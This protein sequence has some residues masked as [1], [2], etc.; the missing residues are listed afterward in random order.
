MW[1][2]AK[3]TSRHESRAGLALDM[4]TNPGVVEAALLNDKLLDFVG[5]VDCVGVAATAAIVGEGRVHDGDPR[6]DVLG[7]EDAVLVPG[8]NTS[9]DRQTA[10]LV[11]DAARVAPQSVGA[12]YFEVAQAGV[13]IGRYY[14]TS[15]GQCMWRLQDRGARQAAYAQ[16]LFYCDDFVWI[17]CW[18]YKDLVMGR[19]PCD[20]LP[21]GSEGFAGP[22]DKLA[23]G[24]S[25]GSAD[26]IS[27]I[28]AV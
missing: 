4:V 1:P 3:V 12:A 16:R 24:T 25:V 19:S 15:L 20:R 28:M 27:N 13:C 9:R 22:D 2:D 14:A 17:R 7:R 26:T 10:A 8:K 5:R 18:G 11:P 6:A 21:N 23:Q